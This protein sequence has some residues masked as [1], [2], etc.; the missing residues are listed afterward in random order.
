MDQEQKVAAAPTIEHHRIFALQRRHEIGTKAAFTAATVI[1][2]GFVFWLV[3]GVWPPSGADIRPDPSSSN[4]AV[5]RN[6][7]PWTR[8][9]RP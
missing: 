4:A 1:A 9:R 2:Y 3:L 5:A 6:L 7:Q 8:T